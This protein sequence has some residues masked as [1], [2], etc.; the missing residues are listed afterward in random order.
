MKEALVQ[1]NSRTG[2]TWGK[3]LRP[4]WRVSEGRFL[5]TSMKKNCLGLF[6][7]GLMVLRKVGGVHVFQ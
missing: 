3:D 2:G 6:M 5:R 4:R 7:L 1:L